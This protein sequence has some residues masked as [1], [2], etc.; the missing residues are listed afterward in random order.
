MRCKLLPMVLSV[1]ATWQQAAADNRVRGLEETLVTAQHRSESAQSIPISLFTM[2]FE[3]LQKQ[4][5]NGIASLNG[6]V[7]NLDIDSFPANNQTLRLFIRGVGL[8]DTQVTQDA[9]VGVYLNGAYIARSTGLAL[10]IVELERIEILRGPQ[11]TLYGR[12]TTGGA[13]N[14][15]TKKPD[16]DDTTFDQTLS[17]GNRD[18]FS[19]KTSINL[20]LAN[21]Y[22]AKAAYFYQDVDGFVNNDGPG[23][24]FGDRESKGFRLDFRAELSAALTLDYGYDWSD[25][26]YYNYTAQAVT[27][28]DPLDLDLLGIVGVV[29]EQYIDYSNNKFSSLATSVPLLPTDTTIDGHTL[30]LNWVINDAMSLRSITAYREL[31]DKSYIDFASGASGEFRIDYTPRR[32][33]GA[34]CGRKTG[35][36]CPPS[37]L[38]LSRSNSHKSYTCLASSE[39]LSTTC[40]ACITSMKKPKRTPGHPAPHLQR[41]PLQQRHALQYRRR[42]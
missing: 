21:N 30:N 34:T 42:I 19:S 41:L 15:I 26:R 40:S 23:G 14:I 4:R 20:P 3:Q 32:V 5:I 31:D 10:D 28:R 36:I 9:A 22:A 27:P 12:N 35:W 17:T 6:L 7:P 24:S 2:N 11:G 33:I 37:D 8:T 1:L 29:A 38:I 18:L 16:M 13:L 39:N 25:I